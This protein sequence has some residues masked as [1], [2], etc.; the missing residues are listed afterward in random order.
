MGVPAF[1]RWISSKF[2]SIL[3]HATEDQRCENP[4][5][6]DITQPNPNGVEFDNLYL[7]MNGIIHP[8]THPENKPAPKNEAE[9]MIAIFEYI[10]RLMSICRP[11]RLLYMAVDG[12][13]P[14]AKM[15]QQ[16]SRRF[17]AAKD[18]ETKQLAIQEMRKTL[19]N[20]GVNIDLDNDKNEGFDSN[21]ITPGTEFM[22]RLSENLR[23]YIHDRLTNHP[24]WNHLKVILSDAGCPGE[25]EHKVV[26]Y[27]RRQ[28]ADPSHDPN[29][30]HLLCGADADL[31][32]LGLATHEPHFTIIREEFR[33][34]PKTAKCD[35]CGEIGHEFK[36][37]TGKS[38][39]RSPTCN[40]GDEESPG[41]LDGGDVTFL[42]IRL[43]V[44]REYLKR[45]IEGY[46]KHDLERFIDDWVFLCF[47][48]GNDF[49]PHLPS[50]ETRENAV[51]R[52]MK[53][54][55]EMLGKTGGKGCYLTKNGRPD[56]KKTEEILNKIG[57]IEDEIFRQ[58][59][60][61]D[62]QQRNKERK[63]RSFRSGDRDTF[64]GKKRSASHF[65]SL[66]SLE[67]YDEQEEERDKQDA[68]KLY[69][70]GFKER[71]YSSKFNIDV[72][73]TSAYNSFRKEICRHYAKGISWVLQYYYQGVPAWDW[74]YPYH[75]A[76]FASDFQ[77]NISDLTNDFP[78]DT[79]PFSPFEQLMAVFP[80]ASGRFLPT[81]WRDL[82][83]NPKSPIIDFYPTEFG[84]DLNGKRFDWQAVVL[85]PFVSE[86][87]L[88]KALDTVRDNLT[89]EEVLRN[90]TGNE[91]IFVSS[92]L[93]ND[94]MTDFLMSLKN[95]N[96][97]KQLPSI[98]SP[99]A[100]SSCGKFVI[101]GLIKSYSNSPMLNGNLPSPLPEYTKDLTNVTSLC[102]AYRN[103][104]YPKG[105]VFK[106]EL[107]PNV[108]IPDITLKPSDYDNVEQY[109]PMTGFNYRARFGNNNASPLTRGIRSSMPTFTNNLQMPLPIGANPFAQNF[110][111][112]MY[113]QGINNLQYH[114]RYPGYNYQ[115]DSYPHQYNFQQNNSI[116]A[117]AALLYNMLPRNNANFRPRGNNDRPY[118]S[119]R[120]SDSRNDRKR[121]YK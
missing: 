109:K 5:D 56:M 114:Q 25:G 107:L 91:L 82:M 38:S 78:E 95:K 86:Q 65:N 100:E 18:T 113:Q 88:F 85:L 49:V 24:G 97:W 16:R 99:E 68:V 28:R 53:I 112:T 61:K 58:R 42:F 90:S 116:N 105:F 119:R 81:T 9:M 50:L 2:P 63:R 102:F 41:S 54:Y 121:F 46:S 108:R 96:K 30:H 70:A 23:Y 52:L 44:L 115:Q 62:L 4:V 3:V 106:P 60:A 73:D 26:D 98:S 103:P 55:I 14:R 66:N 17:R 51:D 40:P 21:C 74:Y 22:W 120:S 101:A 93:K 69:N 94:L 83:S 59:R 118:G 20:S 43:N 47:F 111:M 39:K 19:S 35:I 72:N 80:A 36:D 89:E 27:I 1:F 45:E 92:Q 37:C 71:Y 33:F 117:A 31:M 87:R 64:Y 32:M 77:D 10:D 8:C 48:V 6:V 84:L 11:R 15:N 12:V 75:Y 104:E 13:A 76:P 34:Q 79:K 110:A 67:E 7:D 57:V 29:T